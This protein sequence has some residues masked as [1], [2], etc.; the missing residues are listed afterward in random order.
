MNTT[1][2]VWARVVMKRERK[3]R[4]GEECI[5]VRQSRFQGII[6]LRTFLS[7][8]SLQILQKSLVKVQ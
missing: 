7:S 5:H 1:K 3:S 2:K 6:Q 4:S 8:T